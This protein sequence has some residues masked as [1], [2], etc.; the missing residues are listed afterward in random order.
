[1]PHA[2]TPWVRKWRSVLSRITT[3]L[4]LAVLVY[5][6]WHHRLTMQ[7]VFVDLGTTELAGLLV[8]LTLGIVLSALSFTILVR[9]MGYRFTCQDG[10]HSLNLSQIAAMVP[11]K[12]WG[13]TGLAGSLWSRGISKRDSLLVIFLYT[14]LMLSAAVLVGAAGLIPTIGWGYTLLCLIPVLLLIAGRSW[15]DTLRL[16]YFGGS[17]ALPSPQSMLLILIVGLGSWIVVSAC[18]SLLVYSTE[19]HW[20]ASPL[21][22]ASAFAAG[23]VGGFISPVTPAGLGVREGIIT[24]ILGPALGSEKALAIA[25]VFRAVHMAVIWLHIAITLFALSFSMRIAGRG[26]H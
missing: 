5:W 11:G 3:V 21:L 8:L 20:P 16:R 24:I 26:N 12:I 18:F 19:R 1:M 22:F 7:R 10:Y 9:S 4:I 14:L 13:F 6:G 2:F 15:F 17:S 23:Y 25:I